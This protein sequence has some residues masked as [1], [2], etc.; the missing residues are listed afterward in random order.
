[1][2][3]GGEDRAE[4][5]RQ[6]RLTETQVWRAPS[7]VLR[8]F[9]RLAAAVK[10]VSAARRYSRVAVGLNELLLG[11]LEMLRAENRTERLRLGSPEHSVELFLADLRT[12]VNNLRQQWTLEDMAAACGMGTTLFSRMCRRLANDSPVRYLNLA[13]LDAAMRMLRAEPSKGVTE[14][15]F[16]CGFQSSQYFANQFRRRFGRTPSEHRERAGDKKRVS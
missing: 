7:D 8:S 1:V 16:E 12:N 2:L 6:L 15:A 4:L 9:R 5:A 11:V 3:L 10:E 13:R 14:V